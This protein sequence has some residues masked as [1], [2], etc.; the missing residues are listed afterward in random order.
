MLNAWGAIDLELTDGRVIHGQYPNVLFE[1][2]RSIHI[3]DQLKCTV[4][5]N[6]FVDLEPVMA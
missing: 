1:K 4:D 2:I 6:T 3:G 5:S